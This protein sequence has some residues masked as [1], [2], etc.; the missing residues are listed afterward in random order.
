MKIPRE[1]EENKHLFIEKENHMDELVEAYKRGYDKGYNIGFLDG[2]E[3]GWE[4]G[5]FDGES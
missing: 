3:V 5:H 1:K 4:E 2:K